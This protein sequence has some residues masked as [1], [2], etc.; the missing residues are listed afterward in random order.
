M[1][2]FI[3]TKITNAMRGF[4]AILKT[5]HGD[6][7]VVLPNVDMQDLS[8]S[9]A[10]K[11]T[12]ELIRNYFEYCI[13]FKVVYK[14]MSNLFDSGLALITFTIKL[15]DDIPLRNFHVTVSKHT[16]MNSSSLSQNIKL[17]ILDTCAFPIVKKCLPDDM[18]LTAY[19]EQTSN[20]LNH[21]GNVLG[22]VND[23]EG[24]DYVLDT[25]E[26]VDD[27]VRIIT[28]YD[29]DD[30]KAHITFDECVL[31]DINRYDLIISDL[32]LYSHQRSVYKKE[33]K[34]MKKINDAISLLENS[35]YVVDLPD[36][37]DDPEDPIKP[38]PQQ[39][40]TI[41]LYPRD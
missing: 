40:Y 31:Y 24:S 23:I 21:L 1:K 27:K 38:E 33:K 5:E 35:G 30:I 2:R 29:D 3:S 4:K 39:H 14:D 20:I 8:E 37:I 36:G 13:G 16:L 17:A 26:F 11:E 34:R 19:K 41:K 32:C 9:K 12:I 22:L 18:A 25:F 15:H 28:E 7:D 6:N 10:A